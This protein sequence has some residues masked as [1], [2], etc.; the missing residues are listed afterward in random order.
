MQLEFVNKKVSCNADLHEIPMQCDSC[1]FNS[2]L[3][4]KTLLGR[5]KVI[6]SQANHYKIRFSIVLQDM[7]TVLLLTR[8]IFEDY[9]EDQERPLPI[10]SA[11]SY[12]IM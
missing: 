3:L 5:A 4:T 7:S 6:M 11:R 12:T 8:F 1:R 9:G 10:L 2:R